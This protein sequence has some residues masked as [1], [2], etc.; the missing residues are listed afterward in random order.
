MSASSQL[1]RRKN[2]GGHPA[3]SAT[4]LRASLRSG[5]VASQ[6]RRRRPGVTAA[7]TTAV[8]ATG[9]GPGVTAL[10]TTAVFATGWPMTPTLPTRAGLR[11]MSVSFVRHVV[12]GLDRGDDRLDGNPSVRDELSSRAPSGGGEWCRP[13]VFPDEDSGGASRVHGEGEVDD[14]IR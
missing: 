2:T 3:F 5:R 7:A 13:E 12:I 10:A 1:L 11:G 14:V 6:I 4:L 8:F 9:A